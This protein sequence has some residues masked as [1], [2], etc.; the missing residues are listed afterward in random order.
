[1]SSFLVNWGG[2][3]IF[4]HSHHDH[5]CPCVMSNILAIWSKSDHFFGTCTFVHNIASCFSE[6]GRTDY[7][8]FRMVQFALEVGFLSRCRC[9]IG[10][11]PKLLLIEGDFLRQG[12]AWCALVFLIIVETCCDLAAMPGFECLLR[13]GF[14]EVLFLLCDFLLSLGGD[15]GCFHELRHRSDLCSGVPHFWLETDLKSRSAEKIERVF[16]LSISLLS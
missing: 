11:R 14:K 2:Q 1:M 16:R 7:Q 3:A 5:W 4:L 13:V 6:L 8:F 15:L 10:I 9:L 12:T